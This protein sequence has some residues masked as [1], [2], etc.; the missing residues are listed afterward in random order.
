MVRHLDEWDEEGEHY[1]QL[2]AGLQRSG[3]LKVCRDGNNQGDKMAIT[4]LYKL[5]VVSY[6]D[7][8]GLASLADPLWQK[9]SYMSWLCTPTI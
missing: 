7:T 6:L 9:C 1:K 4:T 8:F 2:R 5:S 3:L